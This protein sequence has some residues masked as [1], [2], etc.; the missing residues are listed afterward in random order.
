[1]QDPEDNACQHG[2]ICVFDLVDMFI[3]SVCFVMAM[4]SSIVVPVCLCLRAC[5]SSLLGVF[6]S[7]STSGFL[8]SLLRLGMCCVVIAQVCPWRATH[9]LVLALVIA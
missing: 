8:G 4:V 6:F 5:L 9:M 3:L 2:V 7:V 1:M